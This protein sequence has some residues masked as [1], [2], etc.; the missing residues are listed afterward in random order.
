MT[1]NLKY[2]PIKAIDDFPTPTMHNS[3]V[4]FSITYAVILSSSSSYRSLYTNPPF[5]YLLEAYVLLATHSI[6][7]QFFCFS[8]SLSSFEKEISQGFLIVGETNLVEIFF[9]VKLP[10]IQPQMNRCILLTQ[11]FLIC[12]IIILSAGYAERRSKAK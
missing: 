10:L 9:K 11:R 2:L 6:A 7:I 8:V 5:L 12:W 4:S 1:T 3:S